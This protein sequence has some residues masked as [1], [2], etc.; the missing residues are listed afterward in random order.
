MQSKPI[1]LGTR[2]SPLALAQANEVRDR[3][4]AAW[5]AGAPEVEI[6]TISTAGDRIQDRPLSEVGG[7]GLFTEEIEAGLTSGALDI[8][9]H[10]SKD[11]PTV[12]PAGLTLAHFLPREDAR[13]AFVS[14]KYTSLAEMPAGAVVG[15]ASLRRAAIV[16]RLRPDLAIVPY[17]GN[18]QTRLR[19]LVEGVADATLLAVAGLK[20][21]GRL[22]VATDILDIE[23]FPPAVGQGAIGIESR[24][25]DARVAD[26]LA[27]IHHAPTAMALAAERAYLA[28]LDGSCRTPIAG[29]ATV[30]GARVDLHG[31]ILT[32]DGRVAHEGR[33]SGDDPVAVGDRLGARLAVLAGPGFFSGG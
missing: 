22:D 15:T 19:K 8:A 3:L 6:V 32:P 18:V 9:V 17:R 10:S 21:L 11:M 12:L 23:T 30:T 16:R 14:L 31:L 29:Y 4:L 1:R 25:D 20:R 33:E 5:G 26:L 27:P 7:K 13:D 28:R 24:I 2:G